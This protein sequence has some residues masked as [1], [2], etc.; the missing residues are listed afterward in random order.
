MF[1]KKRF[2]N[3]LLWV[4]VSKETPKSYIGQIDNTPIS[5]RYKKGQTVRVNKS[6]IL[7]IKK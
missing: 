2:G 1:V 3:E 6:D 4:K 5:K 7:N